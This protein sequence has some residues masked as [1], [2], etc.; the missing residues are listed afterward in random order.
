MHQKVNLVQA[1]EEKS[2][3]A[4]SAQLW[5]QL[6]LSPTW[7]RGCSL[8]DPL[9]PFLSAM[10]R[11]SRAAFPLVT[12]TCSSKKPLPHGA[13]AT[14]CQSLPGV[15]IAQLGLES[16]FQ[17]ILLSGYEVPQE[18]RKWGWDPAEPGAR[19]WHMS[20]LLALGKKKAVCF[21]PSFVFQH[22]L[23]SKHLPVSISIC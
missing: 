4:T 18:R 21:L 5:V 10:A 12:L 8:S 9:F 3:L 15:F 19:A 13:W 14:S 2:S 7:L 23:Q 16:N 6:E 20:S 22:R 11:G 1:I 17:Q